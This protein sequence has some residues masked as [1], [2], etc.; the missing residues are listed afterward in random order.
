MHWH[1]TLQLGGEL[2]VKR[3]EMKVGSRQHPLTD[4]TQTGLKIKKRLFTDRA[5]AGENKVDKVFP[6]K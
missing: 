6:K 3:M 5:I 2:I 1:K 4:R